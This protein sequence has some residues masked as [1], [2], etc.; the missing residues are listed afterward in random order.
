MASPQTSFLWPGGEVLG[1][2]SF[3]DKILGAVLDTGLSGVVVRATQRENKV[4]RARL[5][6][7]KQ[8]LSLQVL[9]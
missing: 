8:H 3:S 4:L 5:G 9:L 1:L 2:I 6:R 7:E